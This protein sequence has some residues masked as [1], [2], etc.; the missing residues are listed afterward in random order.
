MNESFTQ[1][2][3]DGINEN[4]ERANESVQKIN[5]HSYVRGLRF[6]AFAAKETADC[7]GDCGFCDGS[8]GISV[9]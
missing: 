6:V 9:V 4:A 1:Q 7:I 2:D 5:Y 3:F 8:C